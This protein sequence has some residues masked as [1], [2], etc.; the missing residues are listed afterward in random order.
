MFRFGKQKRML[1]DVDENGNVISIDDG[2]IVKRQP[3]KWDNVWEHFYAHGA[4]VGGNKW[5][6]K[7][8]REY[9][10]NGRVYN[11][12]SSKWE[13]TQ[14]AGGNTDPFQCNYEAAQDYQGSVPCWD[15]T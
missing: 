12:A 2:S 8:K 4:A 13:Y 15:G 14:T 11:S 1:I 5:K 7:Y 10:D 3:S 9:E 6:K